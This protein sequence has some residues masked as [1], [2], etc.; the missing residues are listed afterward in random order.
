MLKLNNNVTI[1]YNH[2][3]LLYYDV[4]NILP[5]LWHLFVIC[6]YVGVIRYI[7]VMSTRAHYCYDCDKFYQQQKRCKYRI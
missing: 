3:F 2:Y 4:S 7:S 6:L 1:Y 5:S